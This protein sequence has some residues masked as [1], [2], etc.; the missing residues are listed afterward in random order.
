MCRLSA[1][2][3]DE[4]AAVRTRSLH[5][6]LLLRMKT[7]LCVCTSLPCGHAGA[8]SECAMQHGV[9]LRRDRQRRR[10]WVVVVRVTHT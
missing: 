10:R 5:L 1:H 6:A 8:I 9:V 2:S 7:S 3:R 4:P